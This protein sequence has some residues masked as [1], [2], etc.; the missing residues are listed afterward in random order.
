[1]IKSADAPLQAFSWL[2]LTPQVFVKVTDKSAFLHGGTGVPRQ[3]MSIFNL[4][5][6]SPSNKVQ[7]TLNHDGQAYPAHFEMTKGGRIRLMWNSTFSE[8]LRNTCP[9]WYEAFSSGSPLDAERPKIDLRKP[10]EVMG[11][12]LE[13]ELTLEPIAG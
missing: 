8:F 7:I 13:V 5:K 9:D 6:V 4:R 12:E 3:F 2:S 1:M 11:D 10:N